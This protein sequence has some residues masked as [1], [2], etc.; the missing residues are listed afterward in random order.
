MKIR[1]LELHDAANFVDLLKQ[2]EEESKFMLF[3]SGERKLST[4]QQEKNIEIFKQ[5]PNST[6]IVAEESEMLVGY[7]AA[8][9]GEAN[10]NA[11]I[12]A[13]TLGIRKTFQ[14]Q[15]IG[16]ALF[17]ALEEWA[18]E[19]HIHRLELTVAVQHEKALSLYDKVGFEIEGTKKHSLRIGG[20]F[21]DE[22]YMSK[23]LN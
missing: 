3:E 14:N 13:L 20:L 15:G 10:R 12:A 4:D 21:I 2:I 8:T 23:L 7:I 6:I 5:Q 18:R 19:H 1:E 11:H 17:A 22:Y 9:G 16:T